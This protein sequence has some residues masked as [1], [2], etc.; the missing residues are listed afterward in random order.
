MGKCTIEAYKSYVR[1]LMPLV[2][3]ATFN[4]VK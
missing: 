2:D 1:A 3:K 4:L